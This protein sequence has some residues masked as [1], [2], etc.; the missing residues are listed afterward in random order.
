M[1][2]MEILYTYCAIDIRRVMNKHVNSAYTGNIVQYANK[3]KQYII[4]IYKFNM[5]R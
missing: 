3:I 2:A 4:Y 5:I 1:L